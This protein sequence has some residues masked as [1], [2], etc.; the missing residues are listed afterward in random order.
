MGRGGQAPEGVQV[1]DQIRVRADPVIPRL[2]PILQAVRDRRPC[3][4]EVGMHWGSS[5]AMLLAGCQLPPF[6]YGFEC[7][8]RN[9]SILK[10]AGFDPFPFAVSDKRGTAML[11][12]CGGN[13]PQG[14]PHLASSSIQEPTLHREAFPWCTFDQKIEVQTITLDEVLNTEP[15]IDVIWCDCQG[16][17]RKVLDGA[18]ET[19]AKTRYL[20]IE[21]H[22][23]PLYEDEPT[24]EELVLMLG[25]GWE[26]VERY[27]AD[28]LFCNWNMMMDEK[29]MARLVGGSKNSVE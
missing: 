7:D 27:E 22:P 17:Q 29:V 21:V 4:V 10:E 23:T 8:P 5:T 14:R 15:V 6:Y 11:N 12:L 18:K 2:I 9:V 25:P 1:N 3:I 20:Y 26:V 28:V 24:F 13:D 16:A 19:L